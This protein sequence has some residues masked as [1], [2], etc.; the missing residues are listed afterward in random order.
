[1]LCIYDINCVNDTYSILKEINNLVS[2]GK[3]VTLDLR[4]VELIT[5]AAS[6]LLFATVNTCQLMND[7][8]TQVMCIFPKQKDNEIGHG[9]IVKTGLAKALHAGSQ[10]KL[11]ELIENEAYFQ[12][13][14]QPF[15]HSISTAQM[16]SKRVQFDSVQYDLLVTAISEAMLNVKHHAYNDPLSTISNPVVD[17]KKELLVSK[18]GLRWWQCAWFDSSKNEWVFI[19]CDIGLGIPESMQISHKRQI[20]ALNNVLDNQSAVSLAF[21]KGG[22]RFYSGGRGNG[23]EDMK[24]AIGHSCKETDNLLVYSGGIR[25]QYSKE[26]EKPDIKILN[27][28][29][30]GTLIEW[31]LK[32]KMNGG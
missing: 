9:F 11:N 4:N 12:S 19:I 15:N 30:N 3:L 22:S 2:E 20:S 1:M 10:E 25:Y 6:V 23:S 13:S 24:R 27:K 31:T 18:L 7:N 14:T 32:P 5:A 16:L 29:I 21:T 26:M 17:T 28:Y 8:P